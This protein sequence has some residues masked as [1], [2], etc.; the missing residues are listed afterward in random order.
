LK[1]E[2][3]PYQ[4]SWV[5]DFQFLKAELENIL[6]SFDPVIEHIGSTSVPGLAAKPVIDIMVGIQSASL[7][8]ELV[9]IMANQDGYIYYRCFDDAM[10]LRRLYVK[11]KQTANLADFPKH[12]DDFETIPHTTINTYRK[13]HVHIWDIH[14]KDWLR[15]IAF[16]DYLIANDIVRNEYQELKLSLSQQEW[17]DGVHYN[18]AKDVFIKREERKALEWRGGSYEL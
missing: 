7:F 17:R 13:A 9:S 15:H 1:I 12:Y 2:V 6:H 14:S 3:I 18:E 10:P 8:E 4:S 5:D 16:R 11:L